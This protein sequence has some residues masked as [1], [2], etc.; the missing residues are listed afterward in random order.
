MSVYLSGIISESNVNIPNNTSDVTVNLYANWNSGSWA[1]DNPAGYIIIDG[2]QYNFTANFNVGQSPS[3][4][5]LIRTQS[6]TV[7]HNTAESKTAVCSASYEGTGY[8]DGTY[9]TVYWN[10]SLVLT[11]IPRGSVIGS[12]TA[13][14]LEDTFSVPITKY[15]TSFVDNLTIKIGSTTIHTEP[16]YTSGAAIN[17]SDTEILSA[18]NALGSN[19]SG[20]VIFELVTTSGGTQIGTSSGAAT[21]IAAGTA[22]IKVGGHW[23]RAVPHIKA[24][25]V[26]KKAVMLM[27]DTTWKRGKI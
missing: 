18:Y 9:H 17:L 5:Q 3:G 10:D 22:Y 15:S 7:S 27:K 1:N 23:T 21:G 8:W 20:S 19:M 2:T 26:W 24:G 14:N 4:L 25:G 11:N 6:K 13:F 16:N 12:L